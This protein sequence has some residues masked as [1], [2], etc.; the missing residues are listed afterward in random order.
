MTTE[1]RVP[2]YRLY[3]YISIAVGCTRFPDQP[4]LEGNLIKVAVCN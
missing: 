4:T 3:R 2:V 1:L